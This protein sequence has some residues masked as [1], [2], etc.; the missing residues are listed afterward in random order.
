M[1]ERVMILN[2]IYIILGIAAL[3]MIWL[4]LCSGINNID[5][6]DNDD[7]IVKDLIKKYGG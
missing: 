6:Q 7:Q 4:V 3:L 1:G 2:I 5:I